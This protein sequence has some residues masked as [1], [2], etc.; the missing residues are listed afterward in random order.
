[1][2]YL[3]LPTRWPNLFP[4][5]VLELLQANGG[6]QATVFTPDGRR[7]AAPPQESKGAAIHKAFEAYH[8]TPIAEPFPEHI[9]RMVEHYGCMTNA[10][11]CMVVSEVQLSGMV[12][13]MLS[14]D[15]SVPDEI[16]YPAAQAV[17]DVFS[18]LQTVIMSAQQLEQ[19]MKA[20]IADPH[21]A[22]MQAH[23]FW[24][25]AEQTA[26]NALRHC[27][28]VAEEMGFPEIIGR[29]DDR[30]TVA[31]NPS[32]ADWS[33]T[34]ARKW[35]VERASRA[36][37]LAEQMNRLV[38]ELPQREARIPPR[39]KVF[40]GYQTAIVHLRSYSATVGWGHDW[41]YLHN[42]RLDTPTLESTRRGKCL[43]GWRIL[44]P[45]GHCKRKRQARGKA[46]KLA[47]GEVC[48][49]WS[50][51][52]GASSG[53]SNVASIGARSCWPSGLSRDRLGRGSQAS[54]S[55]TGTDRL[56][57]RPIARETARQGAPAWWGMV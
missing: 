6:W 23:P 49:C 19:H 56:G 29:A 31:C 14:H 35:W 25:L 46:V 30:W 57:P 36:S 53:G 22:T 27:K 43:K 47:D 3:T 17:L 18:E 45:D 28:M 32:D 42:G 41:G 5:I 1:M 21:G 9:D 38:S 10:T 2:G 37:A 44:W 24:K 12:D 54:G 50:R 52:S 26:G 33:E 48:A 34:M 8:G 13:D 40:K 20:V 4:H 39:T 11:R 51:Q 16:S 55:S 15:A 7:L